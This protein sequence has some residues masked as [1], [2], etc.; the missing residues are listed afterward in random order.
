MTS[1]YIPC[2]VIVLLYWRI[3]RA[4]HRRARRRATATAA[5]A[6]P[7]T[8]SG[9]TL[10]HQRRFTDIYVVDNHV[11]PATSGAAER[12]GVEA[13]GSTGGGGVWTGDPVRADGE[14]IGEGDA[15]AA[16]ADC[17]LSVSDGSPS[18]GFTAD[19]ATT[20]RRGA[21]AAG[22]RRRRTTAERKIAT[23]STRERR[24][25]PSRLTRYSSSARTCDPTSSDH[26]SK[27]PRD[28]NASRRERKA[29]KTLA[30][31]LGTSRQKHNNPMTHVAH[32]MTF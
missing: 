9:Q 13:E 2:V 23:T 32:A 19:T 8:T 10:E 20:T 15:T 18:R 5:A 22:R 16:V 17:V 12:P 6:A 25:R 11:A 1:F 21:A 4:I 26:N 29:T 30:I 31:V 3:F 7:A 28:K 27:T 14:V 24:A